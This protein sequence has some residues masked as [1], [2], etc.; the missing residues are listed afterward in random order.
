MALKKTVITAHGFE[1]VDAYH[2]VESPTILNK[3]SVKFK[4]RSYVDPSKEFFNEQ[5]MEFPYN[6]DGDNPIKQAYDQIKK[7]ADFIAAK[8]C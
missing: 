4:L 7:T 5:D 1:A 8:D 2:R 6:I 3:T